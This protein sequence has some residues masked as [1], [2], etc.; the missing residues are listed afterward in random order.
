MTDEE[1]SVIAPLFPLPKSRGR[2]RKTDLREVVNAILYLVRTG[3]GWE[4]MPAQF[5]R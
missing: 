4:L 5:A 1:W 2:L 3:C